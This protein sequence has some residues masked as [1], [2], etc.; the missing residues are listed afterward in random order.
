MQGMNQNKGAT[1]RPNGTSTRAETTR[2]TG[3]TAACPTAHPMAVMRRYA[4]EMD[5][6]LE[7]FGVGMGFHFPG[8][9]S[10]GHETVRRSTG[11]V[12]AQWSPRVDVLGRDGNLVVQVDLPGVTTDQVRVEVCD[13]L[14]I[15]QGERATQKGDSHEGYLYNERRIGTFYRA[16]PLPEGADPAKATAAF[17]N[18]VLE[19]VMPVPKHR[20]KKP[21]RVEIHEVN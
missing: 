14:L 10:R 4:E 3:S 9:L 7:E 16:I 2:P 12:P 21:H 11:L 18:G 6:M 17:H 1:A 20:E 8:F 19:I 15:I 13:D 5:R